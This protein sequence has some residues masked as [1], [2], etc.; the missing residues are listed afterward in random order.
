M[1]K[2]QKALVK[3]RGA[4]RVKATLSQQTPNNSYS[5]R[6]YYEGQKFTCRDCGVESVWKAEQQRRWCEK[7]G[8]SI[9]SKAV[10]CQ[11]CLKRVRREKIEQHT[12]MLDMAREK[13]KGRSK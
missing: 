4:G 12:H 11:K 10:R 1:K 13:K 8:G 3:D 7:W 6:L 9:Y 2:N 5:Q